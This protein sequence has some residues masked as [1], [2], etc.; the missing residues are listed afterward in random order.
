MI[1]LLANYGA[2]LHGIGATQFERAKT[3]ATEAKFSAI[4]E[5]LDSLLAEQLAF[6]DHNLQG[7]WIVSDGNEVV[8]DGLEQQETEFVPDQIQNSDWSSIG[9]LNF[10]NNTL[11]ESGIV[12]WNGVTSL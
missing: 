11:S 7:Q 12:S 8:I 6:V 2:Q 3:L 9:V 10:D 1:Q 4:T 5:L